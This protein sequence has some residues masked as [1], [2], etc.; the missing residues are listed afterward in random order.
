MHLNYEKILNLIRF[1]N[2]YDKIS[3]VRLSVLSKKTGI[4]ISNLLKIVSNLEIEHTINPNHKFS[5][6]QI[7][8]LLNFVVR[9]LGKVAFGESSSSSKAIG[10]ETLIEHF[11]TQLYNPTLPKNKELCNT[12]EFETIEEN[13]AIFRYLVC[14]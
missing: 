2:D 14:F 7:N 3:E 6:N 8:A 11:L 4:T 13:H 1:A 5:P 9:N 10:Y 12:I